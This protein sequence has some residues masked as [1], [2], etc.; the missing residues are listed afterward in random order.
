M[1]TLTEIQQKICWYAAQGYSIK[2]T[3]IALN[4]SPNTI[5]TQRRRIMKKLRAENF[6]KTIVIFD[7]KVSPK[8]MT[9]NSIENPQKLEFMMYNI[10]NGKAKRVRTK[11]SDST[12]K[13]DNSR[14]P[15]T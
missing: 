11:Q 13:A 14:S 7:S 1:K 3:A 9:P 10:S 5:A 4:R 6:F 8:M 12:R 2:Q 15:S